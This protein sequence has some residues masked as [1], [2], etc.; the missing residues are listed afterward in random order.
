MREQLVGK[1]ATKN[2]PL[3]LAAYSAYGLIPLLTMIRVA[4]TPVFGKKKKVQ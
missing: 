1:Y 2:V 4:A 3:F